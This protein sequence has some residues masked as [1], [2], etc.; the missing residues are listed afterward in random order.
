MSSSRDRETWQ[1]TVCA[2]EFSKNRIETNACIEI[3]TDVPEWCD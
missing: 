1:S 3:T 2:R